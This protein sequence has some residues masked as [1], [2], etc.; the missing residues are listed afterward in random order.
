M[1]LTNHLKSMGKSL[2]VE[3]NI[4]NGA[5]D[6]HWDRLD[7]G[8]KETILF[9]HGFSD[10]KE[11]FYAIAR[12]LSQNYNIILP[13]LPGFG[14]TEKRQ[15]L[16]YGVLDYVNWLQ[17]FLFSLANKKVH[18]VGHSLGGAIGSYLA[19]KCPEKVNSLTLV[20]SSGFLLENY[21]TFYDEFLE[22]NSLFFI[23]SPED[24]ETF[25]NRIFHRKIKVPW[26][27]KQFMMKEKMDNREWYR[28]ILTDMSHEMLDSEFGGGLKTLLKKTPFPVNII[29]GKEDSLFP[30]QMAEDAWQNI[31]GCTLKLLEQVGH[32]PHLETPG[33]FVKILKSLFKNQGIEIESNGS[34]K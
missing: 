15:D 20:S 12:P 6:I 7:R 31:P 8:K 30:C 16:R 14:D 26:P 19:I 11:T 5:V 1:M 29:W 24:Y 34:E 27:V 10:T 3:K 23:N 33:Q 2:G 25:V 28:K 18:L 9:I 32:A 22:G 17:P 4:F 21:N 13:Q